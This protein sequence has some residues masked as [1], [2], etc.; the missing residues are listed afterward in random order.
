MKVEA[1]HSKHRRKDVL[2]LHPELTAMLRDWLQGVAAGARLF[3]MLARRKTWKMVKRDLE[4]VGIPYETDAGI[5]DFHAA[6]RHT[7]ITELLRSGASLVEVKELARHSDIKTTMKYAHIGLEDQARAVAAMP[8][9]NLNS[10]GSGAARALQF[11]RRWWTNGGIDW[12]GRHSHKTPKPLREQGFWCRLSS[13][14]I[15][16]LSRGDRT[17]TC[18]LLTPSRPDGGSNSEQQQ[19]LEQGETQHV[20]KHV[21]DPGLAK[22]VA[23]WPGL[24]EPIRRAM[25]ALVE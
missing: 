15:R 21:V 3:P 17:R 7:H 24:P 20:E 4:R 12:H 10:T 23:A 5:A 8:V 18:D 9:P 2:P 14:D 19:D 6:G 22:I 13:T 16:C 25:L 1:R 11:G